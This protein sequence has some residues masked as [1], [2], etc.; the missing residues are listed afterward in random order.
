MEPEATKNFLLVKAVEEA[1][2]EGKLIAFEDRVL[3]DKPG[4]DEAILL[5]RAE[6]LYRDLAAAHPAQIGLAHT[7]TST[8]G[9]IKFAVVGVALLVGLATKQLGPERRIN[10]LA[11]PLFG[12][13][14]WN[15][16]VYLAALGGA[17]LRKQAGPSAAAIGAMLKAASERAMRRLESGGD[18]TLASGLGRFVANWYELTGKARLARAR[19]CLHLGA[20]ALSVGVIAGMYWNGLAYQY[21]AAWESTFLDAA[22][23]QQ[24]FATLFAPAAAISGIA[25][26]GLAE[27]QSMQ[28]T[29]GSEG[30]PAADW[31]HLFAITVGL[32][33]V[34][35]RL[36]MAGLALRRA[37]KLEA[38]IDFRAVAPEYIARVLKTREGGN[39]V[40]RIVPHRMELGSKERDRLRAFAHQLWGGQLWVEFADPIAYGDEEAAVFEQA[41]HQILLLNFS[42]TPEDESQGRLVKR[43]RDQLAGDGLILIEAAPFRE[44]FGGLGEFDRRLNERGEAWAAVLGRANVGYAMYDQDAEAARLAAG[45]V[46]LKARSKSDA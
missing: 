34:L 1:D 8:H 42:A 43:F 7:A 44:R 9:W 14:A 31:I 26:P 21:L 23:V 28:L 39:Q 13:L 27:I 24:L 32:S 38:A 10:V 12:V 4:D 46:M 25:V 41:D 22:G 6:K 15:A 3:E 20:A 29:S 40:A 37:A 45:D 30:V 16:L 17:V 2:R 19:G 5:R 33:V 36:L 18:R 11:F 35:P